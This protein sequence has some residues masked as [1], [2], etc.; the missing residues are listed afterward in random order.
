MKVNNVAKFETH[1]KWA[2]IE[3][4]NVREAIFKVTNSYSVNKV[5]E[6]DNKT[7]VQ[8]NKL[9]N[10]EN[11]IHTS[12]VKVSPSLGRS[13]YQVKVDL[14][15]TA[16]ISWAGTA[17]EIRE[18]LSTMLRLLAPDNEVVAQ[19]WFK[20]EPNTYG[21]TQKQRTRYILEKRESGSKELEVVAQ[22]SKLED[23]IGDLVRATYS[24]ASDAAHQAKEKQEVFRITKYFDVFA[25]D[26][27]DIK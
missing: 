22:V 24:R 5:P 17:H 8:S 18:I 15:D 10:E 27:L 14:L 6:V 1:L 7:Y 13:Y 26:L 23:M 16:R 2:Q 12:L 9:S 3:T 21:P 4:I 19:A 20:Q 25:Y 11:L